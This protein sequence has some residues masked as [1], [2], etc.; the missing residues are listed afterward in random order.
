[1]IGLVRAELRKLTSTR[2]WLWLLLGAVALGALFVSLSLGFA[3]DPDNFSLPLDSELG[4]RTLFATAAGGGTLAAVLGAIG[5]TGEFRHLTATQTFL[6]TPRR[7]RVVV[8]KLI[9]YPLV[10]V[11]YA[12]A[13]IGVVVAIALPWLAAKGI[14]VSL[15]ENGIP[16]TL[17]GVVT[18]MA[19]Y[20]LVGVGLGA[21]VRNQVATVVGLLVYL[22]VV[23]QILTAIPAIESV[24]R[25]LPGSAVNALT[26]VSLGG[27][28]LLE[29]W[30]GGLLLS[31]Y[32]VA[33]ALLGTLFTVRRDVT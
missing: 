21:L 10:G 8:A 4:Q 14:D 7:G 29:P 16:A 32:G 15:L 12:L 24:T 22:F 5:L 33:F 31:A 23:E 19:I 3:D 17:A 18:T 20:A 26:Q 6:A 2:L 1:M 28:D 9:V 25:F 27:Y 30:Q 11:V 13:S